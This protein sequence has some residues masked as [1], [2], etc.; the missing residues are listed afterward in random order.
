M[1]VV[2]AV[3]MIFIIVAFIFLFV[4]AADT[5]YFV[6]VDII[7]IDAHLII[8]HLFQS[9][10]TMVVFMEMVTVLLVFTIINV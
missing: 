5:M 3:E 1:V 9:L 2:G 4:I 8:I 6:V 10:Q 7:V